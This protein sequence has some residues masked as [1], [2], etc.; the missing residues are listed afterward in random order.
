MGVL[1]FGGDAA[2]EQQN[3]PDRI[4][5]EKGAEKRI[6]MPRNAGKTEHTRFPSSPPTLSLSALFFGAMRIRNKAI[7]AFAILYCGAAALNSI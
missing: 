4:R 3:A 6:R 7:G 2:S 5:K 1:L